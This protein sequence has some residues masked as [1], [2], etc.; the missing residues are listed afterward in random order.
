[1]KDGELADVMR[2]LIVME[3]KLEHYA[4]AVEE[5]KAMICGDE[6]RQAEVSV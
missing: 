4:K 6:V 5:L 3:G 2:Y 1:V